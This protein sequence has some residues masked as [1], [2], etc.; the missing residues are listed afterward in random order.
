MFFDAPKSA[1]IT[2]SRIKPEDAAAKDGE[3]DDARRLRAD[4]FVLAGRH[5]QEGTTARDL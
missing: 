3:T 1:A 5:G 2:I 4:P